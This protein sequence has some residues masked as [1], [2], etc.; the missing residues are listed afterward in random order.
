MSRRETLFLHFYHRLALPSSVVFNLVVVQS[1]QEKAS[2]R[3]AFFSL[4]CYACLSLFETP[5]LHLYH[6]LSLPSSVVFSLVVVQSHWEEASS[7]QAFFFPL[8]LCMFVSIWNLVSSF[9]SSFKSSFFGC[10]QLGGC[11]ISPGRSIQQAS[12]FSLCCYACLSLFARSPTKKHP[13]GKVLILFV[14]IHV[15]FLTNT[16]LFLVVTLILPA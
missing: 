2:S 14:V 7:R 9:V 6:R 4:C 5:F 3:Q 8:L 10:L 16:S 12:F 13:A 1:H 11:A 15:F